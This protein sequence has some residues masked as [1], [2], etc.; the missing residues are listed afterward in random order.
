MKFKG[1][2]MTFVVIAMTLSLAGCHKGNDDGNTLDETDVLVMVGDSALRVQDVLQ[3]MP[4]GLS[5]ADSTAMFDAI[6]NAWVERLLLEDFGR[7]NIDDMER[8]ER[9]TAE[10]RARLIVE[11]Y[12]R[13]LRENRSVKVVADSV[14]SY[15]AAHKE[16]FVLERPV[17]KGLFLKIPSDAN[18]L[19]DI[20]RW[21]KSA[22]SEDIDRLEKS[23][24]NEA[25]QFSFFEDR[26]TDWQQISDN[27][28]YRFYDANA[29]VES[30]KDFE[31]EDRGSLY[32]LH[33][34]SYIPAGETMPEEVAY[35]II[36]GLLD[37]RSAAEYEKSLLQSLGK[38][39]LK[40]G[41]LKLVSYPR[42]NL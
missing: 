19:T 34:T 25:L 21:M 8:I 4:G 18:N 30:T 41:R 13:T 5:E 3:R 39:A 20:R 36:E 17:V 16:E 31:T 10:Y 32:L 38:K 22:K 12:R 9:L 37:T 14:K 35:P 1:G 28:P 42:L 6:V 40:E 29:F 23:G 11:S 27:I 26:W 24:L 2:K 15:Y 33:I 7:E